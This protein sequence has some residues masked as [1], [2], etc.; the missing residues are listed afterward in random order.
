M[1]VATEVGW[2]DRE[3]YPFGSHYFEA[4][5][6]RLHYLDE[7]SGPP[8]VM[9]HGNPTW[10]FLYRH[11]VRRFSRSFRCIAPDHL[12]F[13]LSDKPS[14][15]SLHP[16]QHADNLDK[17]IDSL[18]LSD[19]TMVVQDWGGP[20]GLSYAV[21]RPENVSRL[22]IMNTWMWPVNHDP[23]Y[24]AFSRL[25]GGPIGR[26]LIRRTN[27]FARVI[28][29][30]AYGDRRRLTEEIHRH[31]LL[32]LG[33]PAERMQCSVLPGEILGASG[34][35][36]ELW[37]KRAALRSMSALIVWGLDDIAFREKE[38]SRWVDTL[39]E[40]AVVRLSGVGH[41]VQEEAPEELGGA[42]DR[43]LRDQRAGE[44]QPKR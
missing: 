4:P 35:L 16:K 12:G 36:A 40:A 23:Y 25:M 20:I 33:S 31:Y 37:A 22:V 24:F 2:L 30:Q 10:S 41:F 5:Q 44:R 9:V 39:P 34:W 26:L 21:A 11:L 13:G 19:I 18:S 29:R 3:L 38:L 43:L 32:P 27:F 42:I 14:D 7:G 6:G 17:L 1:Q 8:I 15:V 28:M